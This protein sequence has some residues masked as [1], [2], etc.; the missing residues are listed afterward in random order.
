M[1]RERFHSKSGNTFLCTF[2]LCQY[3]VQELQSIK[4]LNIA[5]SWNEAI[6][7][8]LLEFRR[9]QYNLPTHRYECDG[10]ERSLLWRNRTLLAGHPP[11]LIQLARVVKWENCEEAEEFLSILKTGKKE[12]ACKDLLCHFMDEHDRCQASFGPEVSHTAP[13]LFG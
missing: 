6:Q 4:D 3:T 13:L 12:V 11:W 7:T 8:L 5:T 10:Y 2:R 9:L 1:I